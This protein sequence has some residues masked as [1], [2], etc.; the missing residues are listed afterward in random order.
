MEAV[1]AAEPA[2]AA[3]SCSS[4]ESENV[5][6]SSDSTGTASSSS[7]SSNGAKQ[8]DSSAVIAL[9]IRSCSRAGA[10]ARLATSSDAMR[11]ASSTAGTRRSKR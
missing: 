3:R 8:I 4:P 5:S 9:S 2:E 6:S 11:S 10:S 1:E 7:P